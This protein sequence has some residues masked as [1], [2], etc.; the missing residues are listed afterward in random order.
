MCRRTSQKPSDELYKDFKASFPQFN[1]GTVTTS[2]ATHAATS[3]AEA[4]D[5]SVNQRYA[6]Y[7]TYKNNGPLRRWRLCLASL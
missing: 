5:I 4:L 6:L 2:A 1:P 3:L 7:L